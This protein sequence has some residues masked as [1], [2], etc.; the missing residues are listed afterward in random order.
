MK[1]CVVGGGTAGWITLSYLAATT[2]LDLTI[3]HTDEIEIIGVGESTTPALKQVADAVGVDESKWMKDGHATF[4]YGIDFQ[5]WLRPGSN[6]FIV[7]MTNYLQKHSIN[8]YQI[9]D[10]KHTVEA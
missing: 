9:M 5:D 3:I 6:C 4:K 8:P 1:A 2:D 7:L 10:T